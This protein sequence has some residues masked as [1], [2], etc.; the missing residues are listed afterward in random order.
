MRKILSLAALAL[1]VVLVSD[2]VTAADNDE[3]TILE[4]ALAVNADTGEF[5]TLIAAVLHAD[6]AGPLDGRRHFT[7]FAPT[8]EAFGALGL[9]ADNISDL[10][11]EDVAAILL[12]HLPPGGRF[13]ED[14][15]AAKRIRM[16]NKGFTFV[17]LDDQGG[18]FIN[19]AQVVATDIDCSNG[20]IHVIDG[21]LLP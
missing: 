11:A 10:P 5:S 12:Y 16:V 6:L 3:P 15:V 8:D 7:V 2:R 20:V 14:V 17:S 21:V 9:D 13:A 18:V 19:E 4:T 1:S